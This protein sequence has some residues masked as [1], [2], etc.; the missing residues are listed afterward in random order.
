M[1]NTTPSSLG[2]IDASDGKLYLQVKRRLMTLIEQG[3]W[4]P[5]RP[6]PSERQLAGELDVSIGTLRRAVDEL[7]QEQVLVRRQGKGTFVTLHSR[8][9]YL[10]QFFRVEPRALGLPASAQ[11]EYPLVECL[12]FERDRAD[13][14]AAAVLRMREGQ[15]VFVIT[16]RLSLG[17][18]PIVLDRITV[19][20]AQ[21][22]GLTEKRFTER[23]G[24]I[25]NLYQ[26]DFGITVLRTDERARAVLAS[27]EAV[28][29]LGVPAGAPLIEVHRIALT[30]G[31]RPVEYRVSTIQTERHDYVFDQR[32]A[33]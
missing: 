25:Y 32:R 26:T 24:T 31:E 22:K 8:D 14:A 19:S 6:I 21:F 33:V 11:H 3:T 28:R 29:C 13:E 18:R 12:S 27:R 15:P 16:N 4:S 20:A 30:F 10:F 17:R 7:V 9:R 5:G 1:E 2:P 23:S